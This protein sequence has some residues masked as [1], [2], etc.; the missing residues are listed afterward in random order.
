MKAQFFQDLSF[1]KV[2]EFNGLI[3]EQRYKKD[4]IV[5]DQGC[6]SDN[7]YIVKRGKL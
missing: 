1:N 6:E 5:F 3:E 4:E 7:F 2:S